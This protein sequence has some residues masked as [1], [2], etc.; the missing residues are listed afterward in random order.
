L[1]PA[2]I[3]SLGLAPSDVVSV[4]TPTTGPAYEERW[5]YDASFIAGEKSEGPLSKVIQIMEAELASPGFSLKKKARMAAKKRLE[6]SAGVSRR[7]TINRDRENTKRRKHETDE[8][9]RSFRSV[10]FDSKH[11]RIDERSGDLV[12]ENQRN[13][14][15]SE[16]PQCF[17]LRVFVVSCFRDLF[18]DPIN[19]VCPPVT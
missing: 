12:R 15:R 5:S 17:L 8:Q 14:E 7:Q 4:H 6:C 11:S 18:A 19:L 2:I 10:E 1:D 16:K 3:R 9:R 13:G